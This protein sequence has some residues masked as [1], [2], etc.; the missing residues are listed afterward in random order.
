MFVVTLH[1]AN[2]GLPAG[3]QTLTV[4]ADGATTTCSFTLPLA[5]GSG[6]PSCPT[7]PAVQITQA[8]SCVSTG[9]PGYMSQTCTPIAGKFSEVVT[10]SGMPAAVHVTV[11]VGGTTY[12]DDA[13][14]PAYKTSRPNGPNCDP[15]CSQGSDERVL[16]AQ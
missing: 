16:A 13:L 7:G 5:S 15:I 4:T 12:L 14:T 8:M 3:M 11:A 9:T 6:S 10:L 2:G 1:D